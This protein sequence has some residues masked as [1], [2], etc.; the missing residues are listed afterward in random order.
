[1]KAIALLSG[2][3]DSS[4]A[5][6]VILDQGIEVSAVNFI[7][8]FCRCDG[9]EGC[10][11]KSVIVA[12][13]LDIDLKIINVS[14]EYLE[15]V[16]NPNHGYGKNMN[17]CIDCRILMLKKA[18]ELMNEA[19]A[20]FIITG[21]VLGQRPMSQNRKAMDSIEKESGLEGLIVRPLSAKFFPI[22][23]PEKN[24]W[25]KSDNLLH[26]SG[27]SRKKQYDLVEKYKIS[28]FSCP[29]GGCLLT[30]ADFSLRLKTLIDMDM[31]NIY[32]IN[33]LKN[34]RFFRVSDSMILVVGRNKEENER[35]LHL[36][37]DGDLLIEAEA[38]GPAAVGRGKINEEDIK[39]ALKIVARFC[40]A[41]EIKLS[42]RILP[43]PSET[44]VMD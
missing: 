38:R 44:E 9:K 11:K 10:K 31:F 23:I 7:S 22:T 17:P 2:G 12:K 32:N 36:A 15:I 35:L 28:G 29:A 33:L 39:E 1:M 42:Y 6:K 5:I 4:L 41:E 37:K 27:R 20:G 16:K 21:E 43:E 18:K 40:K 8:P 26:I 25:I 14:E 3:L 34:G 30:D 19:G 24:G 13:G